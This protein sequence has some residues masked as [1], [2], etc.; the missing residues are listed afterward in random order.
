MFLCQVFCNMDLNGG[1]WTVIQHR[2]DGSLDFQRGWKEYKMVSWKNLH[3]FWHFIVR[4]S[5]L[6][7][8]ISPCIFR[9]LLKNK[10][11]HFILKIKWYI[12]DI[13]LI[14]H[15]ELINLFNKW[16]PC[17]YQKEKYVTE[18]IFFDNWFLK[19]KWL[20]YP[21]VFSL[22]LKSNIT[23]VYLQRDIYWFSLQYNFSYLSVSF[24]S[25]TRDQT[26]IPCSGSTEP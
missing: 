8:V 25:P 2:E 26:Y 17:V 23:R 15:K 21:K 22:S 13:F 1:G 6:H 12:P 9:C 5:S 24:S 7:Y 19:K 16:F 4:F 20:I 14:K 10:M 11:I 3:S 18:I